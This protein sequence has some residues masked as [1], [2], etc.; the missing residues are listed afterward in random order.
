MSD[1]VNVKK[2][3]KQ[4]EVPVN[5]ETGMQTPY[6]LIQG[7][8]MGVW[9]AIL[10]NKPEINLSAEQIGDICKSFIFPTMR[11]LNI[12]TDYFH[13][14]MS[15]GIVVGKKQEFDEIWDLPSCIIPGTPVPGAI[16]FLHE[17]INKKWAVRIVS[18][19]WH[20]YQGGYKS[21]IAAV[22]VQ[23]KEEVDELKL[24]VGTYIGGIDRD[25]N[26]LPV[27]EPGDSENDQG[28]VPDGGAD[29]LPGGGGDTPSEQSKIIQMP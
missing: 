16:I 17:S 24:L 27:Q 20:P 6:H 10:R 25:G 15:L 3:E 22:E 13:T 28:G 21:I 29:E 12:Q 8:L 1:K 11:V 4:Q 2:T 19:S 9:G 23:T 18:E 26:Q 14:M 7:K 5:P